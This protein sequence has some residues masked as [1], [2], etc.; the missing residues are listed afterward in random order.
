MGAYLLGRAGLAVIVLLATL[1]LL[2]GITLASRA[3]PTD[4]EKSSPGKSRGSQEVAV[5]V[6]LDQPADPCQ[7]LSRGQLQADLEA[8][9][10]RAGV[11]VVPQKT[12][13]TL[14]RTALIYVNVTIAAVDK[15]FAFNAD[16]MWMTGSQKDC[17]PAKLANGHL[18]TSGVVPDIGQV[19]ARVADLLGRFI[20]D[21]LSGRGGP[22]ARGSRAGRL[23]TG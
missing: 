13:D 12:A 8:Q 9:L 21:Y 2:G 22:K 7:A 17:R 4:N 20:R 16:I 10:R 19:R 5:V 23:P 6:D 14:P 3:C 11:T 1:G 15:V 18:E